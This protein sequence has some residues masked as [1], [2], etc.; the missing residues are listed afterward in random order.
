MS[1]SKK[2]AGVIVLLGLLT[3]LMSGARAGTIYVANGGNS[4]IT[5][6]S[7]AGGGSTYLLTTPTNTDPHQIALD[8]NYL[9]VGNDSSTGTVS[10]YYANSGSLISTVAV[11]MSS[12]QDVQAVAVG[13]SDLFVGNYSN[14]SIWEYA[15]G[16][17]GVLGTGTKIISSSALDGAYALAVTGTDLYVSTS[18]DSN[19]V[20]AYNLTNDQL[21]AGF[22]TIAGVTDPGGLAVANGNLYVTSLNGGTV[23]EFGATSGTQNNAFSLSLG[24]GSTPAYLA[25]NT[26]GDLLVTNHAN[27]GTTNNPVYNVGEYNST[28]GAT[29]SSTFITGTNA[30]FG[31]AVAALPLP[32]AFWPLLILLGLIATMKISKKNLLFQPSLKV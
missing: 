29:V 27:V 1:G 16:A 32:P 15:I 26:N 31:I 25:I 8:G 24:S 30:P 18:Y 22:T 23:S 17:G 20:Y 19:T 28:T 10:E 7:T 13:G 21:L 9:F 4:T 12:G 5:T 6:S 3:T 14:G 11:P 2:N